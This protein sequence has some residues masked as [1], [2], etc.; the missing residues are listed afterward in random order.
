VKALSLIAL[1]LPFKVLIWQD[2]T[3][4]TRISYT[5]FQCLRRATGRGAT[6]CVCSPTW[7]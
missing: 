4:Q 5:D 7:P 3:G 1:E 2:S 6:M